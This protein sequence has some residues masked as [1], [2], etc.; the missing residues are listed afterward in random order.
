MADRVIAVVSLPAPIFDWHIVIKSNLVTFSGDSSC[1]MRI[2]V[3]I[4]G[5]PT[6]PL[7]LG[8]LSAL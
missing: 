3:I 7:F 5:G 1:A 8:S 2:L 4:S 6:R